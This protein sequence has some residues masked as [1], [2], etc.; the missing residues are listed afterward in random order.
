MHGA[1]HYITGA[2][3]VEVGGGSGVGV[4]NSPCKM[5]KT[6]MCS[7][8]DFLQT[9]ALGQVRSR[10]RKVGQSGVRLRSCHRPLPAWS[11]FIQA[12]SSWPRLAIDHWWPNNGSGAHQRRR[13]WRFRAGWTVPGTNTTM[14]NH[15]RKCNS[16]ALDI[17][18]H[19]PPPSVAG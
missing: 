16:L 3:S 14:A 5:P 6:V 17:F 19:P 7:C 9:A 4:P 13:P 2:Q 12:N 11:G 18:S 8:E 10:T 15:G 1:S